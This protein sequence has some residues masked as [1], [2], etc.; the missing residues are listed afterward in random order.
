MAAAS[1]IGGLD[2]E[3]RVSRLRAY[4]VLD[5]DLALPALDEL[6]KRAQ[7]V[8]SFPMAWLSFYD[9]KRERLRA[10]AGVAFA[11]LPREQSFAFYREPPDHPVF[12]EDLTQGDHR[13]H[14]LVASGPQVRF[15]G[16]LP[17]ASH[18]GFVVGTRRT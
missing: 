8:S 11:Y 4:G 6:V 14:P 10:R 17:L 16:I 15:V 18:D 2:E 5:P 13:A 1:P 3:E 12:I 9:G 7:D